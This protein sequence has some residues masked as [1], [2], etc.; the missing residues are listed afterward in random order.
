M[1]VLL[2]SPSRDNFLIPSAK[3]TLVFV[4]LTA[5]LKRKQECLT[6]NTPTCRIGDYFWVA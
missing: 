3:A 4:K 2:L 6:T 5:D 1:F